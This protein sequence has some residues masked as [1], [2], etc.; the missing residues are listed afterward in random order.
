M[1]EGTDPMPDA[2]NAFNTE[3]EAEGPPSRLWLVELAFWRPSTL[4][5]EEMESFFP[6]RAREMERPNQ[7][8]SFQARWI[9]TRTGRLFTKIG[10][11]LSAGAARLIFFECP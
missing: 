9:S 11:V 6:D 3:P 1:T 5:D 8:C 4:T 7:S 2:S 10:S